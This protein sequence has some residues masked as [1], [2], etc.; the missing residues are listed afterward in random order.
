M[1]AAQAAHDVSEVH[2]G[3]RADSTVCASIGA[4]GAGGQASR[5][6]TAGVE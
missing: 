5:A 6:A 2:P 3:S 1:G 4:Q